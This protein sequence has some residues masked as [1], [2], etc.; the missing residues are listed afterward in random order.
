MGQLQPYVDSRQLE[1]YV[2]K[3][4]NV[5]A[6]LDAHVAYLERQM[7]LAL[8]NVAEQHCETRSSD[9]QLTL[10]DHATKTEVASQ[11]A[12]EPDLKEEVAILKGKLLAAKKASA[13]WRLAANQPWW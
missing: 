10:V 4:D 1:P 13:E 5:Q 8:S 2:E 7:E 6:A 11:K 9:G 3:H 12:A